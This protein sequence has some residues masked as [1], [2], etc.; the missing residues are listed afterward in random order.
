VVQEPS[1]GGLLHQRPRQA[2]SLADGRSYD[3]VPGQMYALNEH[4]RHTLHA[5]TEL[6]LACMFNPPL[7]G[8]EVHD[9][10]GAY[11]ETADI[12]AG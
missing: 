1:R 2:R 10:N 4:D 12:V 8:N 9:A 11:P 3:I 6:E 5:E 7:Y